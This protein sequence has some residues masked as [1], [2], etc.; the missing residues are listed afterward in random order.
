MRIKLLHRALTC[1]QC[2]HFLGEQPIHCF[3]EGCVSCAYCGF[4]YPESFRVTLLSQILD[5]INHE[6]RYIEKDFT[7]QMQQDVGRVFIAPMQMSWSSQTRTKESCDFI[8]VNSLFF[9]EDRRRPNDGEFFVNCF[10]IRDEQQQFS[11]YRVMKYQ[12]KISLASMYRGLK[13]YHDHGSGIPQ[14]IEIP[15]FES[16]GYYRQ[17]HS[18]EKEMEKE[19]GFCQNWAKLGD[20]GKCPDAPKSKIEFKVEYCNDNPMHYTVDY[21]LILWIQYVTTCPKQKFVT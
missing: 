8:P 15:T 4:I 9:S 21:D 2:L 14:T 13:V 10:R 1:P 12:L 5:R 19:Q 11:H 6:N 3:F 20:V 16:M 7:L 17:S 18:F